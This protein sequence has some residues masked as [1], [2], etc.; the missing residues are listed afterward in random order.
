MRKLSRVSYLCRRTKKERTALTCQEVESPRKE[1]IRYIDV[2][3]DFSNL[4]F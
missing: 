1:S 4:V 3:N 2:P